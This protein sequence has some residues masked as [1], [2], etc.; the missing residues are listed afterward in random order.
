MNN[1][2]SLLKV[3]QQQQQ[4]LSTQVGKGDEEERYNKKIKHE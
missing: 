2:M 4:K 3:W 1:V